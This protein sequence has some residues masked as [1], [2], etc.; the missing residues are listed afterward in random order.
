M[1]EKIKDPYKFSRIMY[2]IEAA[3]EY[4]IA[5]LMA[6]AYLAK[7]T[8]ALGMSDA[9][10][11]VLTSFVSLGCGFQIIA[12]FLSNKT[13]VKRWVTLLHIISQVAFGLIYF[14]PFIRAN[15]LLRIVIFVAV[16]LIAYILHNVVNSPKINWFMSLVPD[17]QRGRFTANKEI[18]SL[19]TGLVFN[20]AVG[21][22]IDY[23]DAQGN[24]SASFLFCGI[25]IFGLMLI[26]SLTLILSKE[27]T[28]Q[29]SEKTPTKTLL[30]GLIKDKTLLKVI[31]VSVFW[32]VANY[33]TTPF[34]G[35]YQNRELAFTM[36][37]ITAI[38]AIAS[39]SRAIFSRPLGKIADKYTFAKMMNICFAIEAVAFIM[40]IFTT[41]S[42][43]KIMYP[44]YSVL[45]AVGMAGINSGEINLIYDYVEKEKRVGALAIKNTFAGVCGFL[46]TLAVS[47]LVNMIQA[48]GNSIFGINVF[49]Q[50]F[51]AIISL[52]C[53][54]LIIL[55][56]NTVIAKMKDKR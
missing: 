8:T 14:V 13:P 3:V 29:V 24:E 42:T 44:I 31:L 19:L 54:L 56:L 6:G 35:T 33:A 10:T 43:G 48:S 53:V 18:V 34:L 25:G 5:L 27:K 38:S 4:F 37:F 46:T 20:M 23:F 9:L 45:H 2:I 28:Q 16:L 52:V 21:A 12:I 1:Q 50:Q 39:V 55:Y 51:V 32:H 47:P 22:V 15:K 30:A 17:E 40:L 11:G 41:P 36:V 26:H 49:A 7:V